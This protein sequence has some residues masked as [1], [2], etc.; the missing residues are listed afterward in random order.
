MMYGERQQKFG[1]DKESLLP[2][3]CRKCRFLFACN[4]ECPK[5]RITPSGE[6]GRNVNYLCRG[7]KFFFSRTE[8][9]FTFMAGELAAGRNVLAVKDV[10]F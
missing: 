7:Y 9:Y 5:N 8:R 3:Q 2:E 4:G 10:K 6:P 1:A